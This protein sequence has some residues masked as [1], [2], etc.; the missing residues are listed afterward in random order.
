MACAGLKCLEKN[1]S[2]AKNPIKK[3]TELGLGML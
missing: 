2:K 1:N 3:L